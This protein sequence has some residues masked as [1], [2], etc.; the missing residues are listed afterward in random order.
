M[1][2]SFDNI[3]LATDSQAASLYAIQRTCDLAIKFESEI[4][5]L[6]V[7]G[8]DE[9]GF[10]D[11]IKFIKGYTSSKGIK[12][13]IINKK[14]NLYTETIKQLKQENFSLVV[15]GT[16]EHSVRIK[17]GSSEVF[18]VIK[19]SNCP[20]ILYCGRTEITSLKEIVLPI[21]DASNTRQK[22][23]YCA[24]LA[25]AFGSTV[26]IYG[27]SKKDSKETQKTVG[28]YIRQTERYLSE[29][30]IKYSVDSKYG[31]KESRAIIA[32]SEQVRAGLVVTMTDTTDSAGIFRKSNAERLVYQSDVPIMWV[33]SKDTRLAGASGY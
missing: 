16:N 24:E 30:G 20:V 31:V 10:E 28:S 17:W 33:H 15:L 6:F 11:L 12:L 21:S 19:N 8:K 32:Y 2:T 9:K 3:L 25:K 13:E 1:E 22:V 18:R 14:G 29:R 26:H 7:A 4:T 5:A 23:P 27:I